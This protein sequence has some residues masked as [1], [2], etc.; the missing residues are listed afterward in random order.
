MKWFIRKLSPII[1]FILTTAAGK[2]LERFEH[3][4]ILAF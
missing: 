4:H 1:T 3:S 2:R